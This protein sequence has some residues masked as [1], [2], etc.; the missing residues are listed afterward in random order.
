MDSDTKIAI[1]EQDLSKLKK[2]LLEREQDL[3]TYKD[4]VQRLNLA[5]SKI[6]MGFDKDL[7]LARNIFSY[8]VPTQFPH[9]SGFHF[10]TKFSSGMRFNGDYL[11]VFEHR[12]R[13]KFNLIMS[14]SSG[15]TLTALLI[16]FLLK[17]GR[18]LG[19]NGA[20]SPKEF[21]DKVLAEIQD[22]NERLSD[23]QLASL[24]VNKKT[25]ELTYKIHGSV[26]CYFQDGET[27]KVTDFKDFS[28][29]EN[30]LMLKPYDRIVMASAGLV[31][32]QGSKGVVFSSTPILE[33]M[34]AM[35][36]TQSVHDLRN[37]VFHKLDQHLEGRRP[38]QDVSLIVMSVE[39]NII[40]LI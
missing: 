27:Q 21:V 36:L 14:S 37:D 34:A 17:Y 19:S 23:I 9:I 38:L 3:R 32:A 16:A 25:Y 4:E 8:L 22:K 10:S 31:S 24:L 20:P 26:F 7:S 2:E 13:F 29:S 40:K 15:P 30:K 28:G 6:L 11:D 35:P 1:L 5:V 18:D 12:D 33:S 39:N